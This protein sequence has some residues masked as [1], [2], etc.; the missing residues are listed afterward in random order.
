MTLELTSR[1]NRWQPPISWRT[2][3]HWCP[4]GNLSSRFV[5]LA[6]KGKVLLRL[7]TPWSNGV[8]HL[9]FTPEEWLEKLAALVLPPPSHLVR[10]GGVFAPNSEYR[11]KIILKP[12]VKKGFQFSAHKDP[13]QIERNLRNVGIDHNPPARGPPRSPC[14]LEL[15]MADSPDCWL[16]E[17]SAGS[18][19]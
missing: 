13:E 7:K 8:T 12:E 11:K 19:L 17:Q 1:R 16:S 2:C 4:I 18:F 6:D 9:E 3:C 14:Q 15:D 10:W 5:E